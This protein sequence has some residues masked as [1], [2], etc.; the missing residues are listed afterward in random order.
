ML[1]TKPAASPAS[2]IGQLLD[3]TWNQT[4]ACAFALLSGVAASKL[5]PRLPVAR[6]DLLVGHG[7]LLT[8]LF[9][10]RGWESGRDVAVISACHVIG[11]ALELVKVSQG[12]WS[13]P[14]PAVLKFAGVPLYGGFLYAAVGSYVCRAWRL[15]DLGCAAI[16]HRRRHWWPPASTSTS[17]ATTGCP[18][19]GGHFRTLQ[20][21]RGAAEHAAG[22][23]VRPDRVLPVGGGKPR[24]LCG[25]L[26][27]PLPAARLAAGRRRQ[28]RCLG[29]AHQRHV[30]ARGTRPVE[31][32]IAYQ[33]A[34]HLGHPVPVRVRADAEDVHLARCDFHDEQHVQPPAEPGIHMEEVAG[35]QSGSLGA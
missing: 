25:R 13:Y 34:L 28:V 3:F 32:T 5:L 21:V 23:V 35:Q 27:L 9:W 30:R 20:G 16:G 8:L 33:V 15:F 6:Y 7:V 26:A 31:D 1:T 14:E 22:A 12:S 4:R 2:R 11:L 17:S 18:R 19:H 24:H 10:R 29:H